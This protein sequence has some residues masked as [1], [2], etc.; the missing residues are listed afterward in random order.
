MNAFI[1]TQKESFAIKNAFY[2]LMNA[3]Q[4]DKNVFCIRRNAFSA[5]P[6]LFGMVSSRFKIVLHLNRKL[7]EPFFFG[8]VRIGFRKMRSLSLTFS[9]ETLKIGFFELMNAFQSVQHHSQQEEN[10]F[11]AVL[12][13]VE[14]FLMNSK[15]S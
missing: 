11:Y 4:S 3:F 13:I 7:S 8:T 10:A 6:Q 14:C 9:R 2:S 5:V 1:K 15:I 12:E